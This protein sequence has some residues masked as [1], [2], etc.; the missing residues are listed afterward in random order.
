V[1][2]RRGG[3]V[4]TIASSETKADSNMKPWDCGGEGKLRDKG[5]RKE[6]RLERLRQQH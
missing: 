2:K 5:V 4:E 6:S 3:A 1:G